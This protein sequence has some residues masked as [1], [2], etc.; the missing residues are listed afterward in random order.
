MLMRNHEKRS[1]PTDHPQ[2][3]PINLG[4]LSRTAI[5]NTA[6]DM[7]FFQGMKFFSIENQSQT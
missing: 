6:P 1:G 5:L 2:E 7:P 3:K 4:H